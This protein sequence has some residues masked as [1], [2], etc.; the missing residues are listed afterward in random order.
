MIKLTLSTIMVAAIAATVI[1]TT[2]NH[3][4]TTLTVD[5]QDHLRRAFL[6]SRSTV[7]LAQEIRHQLVMLPY[8]GVFDWLEGE[9]KEDGTVTLHGSVVTAST[10]SDAE[11]YV[12]KVDGVSRV[13]NEIEV[14]PLSP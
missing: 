11:A 6:Q 7:T 14:L 13:V 12:G 1:A 3:Q 5:G 8:Y 9:V 4:K 10:K 2:P